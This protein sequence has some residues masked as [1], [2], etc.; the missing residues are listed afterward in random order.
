MLAVF[1]TEDQIKR[2]EARA[3]SRF[4][5]LPFADKVWAVAAEDQGETLR[6][7]PEGSEAS[8][9]DIHANFAMRAQ[10]LGVF[11]M[12]PF[13]FIDCKDWPPS[14]FLFWQGF[15]SWAQDALQ[16]PRPL[17]AAAFSSEQLILGFAD[18]AEFHDR[19]TH[20]HAAPVESPLF[21]LPFLLGDEGPEAIS[22]IDV[23]LGDQVSLYPNDPNQQSVH[24]PLK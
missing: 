3:S 7:V 18:S 2:L 24:L 23:S 5:R 13:W 22:K 17:M 21:P 16:T 1:R 11:G 20:A 12:A 15:P 9:A 19:L 10:G 8:W 6:Y 4:L 14:A